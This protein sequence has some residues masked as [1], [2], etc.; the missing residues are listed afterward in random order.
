MPPAQA[1]S[2][3]TDAV[4]EADLLPPADWDRLPDYATLL[5]A[6]HEAHAKTFE[7]MIA[8][9]PLPPGGVALDIAI[10]DGFYTGLLADRDGSGLV[11]GLDVDP[12]FLR[13][14]ESAYVDRPNTRL[15]CGDAAALPLPDGSVDLVWC[16][17][18]LRSLPD[19]RAAVTEWARVLTPDGHIAILENDRLHEVLLPWPPEVELALYHAEC[20]AD[21]SGGSD[22]LGGLHAGRRLH[23]LATECGLR[24]LTK[25]SDVTDA[26]PPSD[27]DRAFLKLYLADLVDRVRPSLSDADWDRVR[28]Y[29]DP[30]GAS[31]L[32]SDPDLEMTFFDSVAL[33]VPGERPA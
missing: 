21:D 20:A 26:T 7:R 18:S 25:Q 17:H 8:A 30:D 10:G 24:L 4:R 11:L 23:R 2:E 14:A 33:M 29:V 31:Y 27:A 12:E 32:A 1:V 9:L 3:A 6:R 16:A 15:L 13:L 19:A 22:E 5:T 28:P